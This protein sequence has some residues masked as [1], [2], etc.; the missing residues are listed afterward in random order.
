MFS[1]S[2]EDARRGFFETWR[3][4]QAQEPVAGIEAMLL[5]V[6]LQHPEYHALLSD[7]EKNLTRDYLPEFGDIKPFQCGCKRPRVVGV[8]FRFTH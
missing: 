2:R 1:P 3:K 4:Y 6:I 8:H 5:E 7:P